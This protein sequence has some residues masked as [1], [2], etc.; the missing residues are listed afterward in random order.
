MKDVFLSLSHPTSPFFTVGNINI[1]QWEAVE[2][3][4]FPPSL[5]ALINFVISSLTPHSSHTSTKEHSSPPTLNSM[6]PHIHV[7]VYIYTC[8]SQGCTIYIHDFL[9]IHEML[10]KKGKATQHNR[11]TKQHNTTC[12]RQ[13]FQSKKL[14]QVGL[15]PTTVRLLHVGDALTN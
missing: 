15:E 14:P 9:I 6:L 2:P 5:L 8:D 4:L 10:R 13:Y 3:T 12:P 1:N 11:K 7:H